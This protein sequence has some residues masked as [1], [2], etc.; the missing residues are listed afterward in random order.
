MK[1]QSIIFLLCI[2]NFCK[3]PSLEYFCDPSTQIYWTIF[4]IQNK[5]NKNQK[6]IC[7][8]PISESSPPY[9]LVCPSVTS[10]FQN[11]GPVSLSASVNGN[12]ILFSISPSLPNGLS[13]D[14]NTGTIS[15]SYSNL[16]GSN[17]TFTL[18][19]TNTAGNLS[20]N[21]TPIF[22]GKKPLKTGQNLCQ[23]NVAGAFIPCGVGLGVGQDRITSTEL[24]KVLQ[25]QQTLFLRIM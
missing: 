17:S 25:D 19:A 11:G 14:S 6:S 13:L 10:S 16:L 9:N 23:D 1:N 18:T 12:N 24:Y 3:A 4:L 20:C 15:G 7:H 8:N 21:F 2:L 5:I 22:F